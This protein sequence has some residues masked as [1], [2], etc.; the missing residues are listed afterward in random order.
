MEA[1][2][3]SVVRVG[4]FREGLFRP[5]WDREAH[6]SHGWIVG[7]L[8]DT[9]HRRRNVPPTVVNAMG[10]KSAHPGRATSV[11]ADFCSESTSAHPPA[12]RFLS[13]HHQDS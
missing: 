7:G 6:C 11:S 9:S 10:S 5:V 12:E 2:Y 1:G 13:T 3:D 4:Y 8:S